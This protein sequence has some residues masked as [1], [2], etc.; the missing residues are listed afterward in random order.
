[1]EKYI[2]FLRGINVGGKKSVKMTELKKLFY[3]MQFQNVKTYINSG[4]V[5]FETNVSDVKYLNKIIESELEKTFGF[6]IPCIIRTLNELIQIIQN[7]PFSDRE[8]D[9]MYVTLLSGKPDMEVIKK[10]NTYKN[11]VDDFYVINREIYL[12]CRSGYH[13]TKFNN[14]FL[15]SKLQIAATTRSLKTLNRLIEIWQKERNS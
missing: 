11:G 13:V 1:M 5:I 9:C 2:V 14:N 6:I 3:D 7:N 8:T 12:Q 4:N 10:L 15:E